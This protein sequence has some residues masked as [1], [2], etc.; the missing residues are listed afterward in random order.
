[1]KLHYTYFS[2]ILNLLNL[3]TQNFAYL[4]RVIRR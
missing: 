3:C 2:L 4:L 1:M